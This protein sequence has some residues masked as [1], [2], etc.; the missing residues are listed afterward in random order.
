MGLIDD[1]RLDIGDDGSIA[2]SGSSSTTL[3]PNY[4]PDTFNTIGDIR[5]DIGDDSN[6]VFATGSIQVP[7]NPNLCEETALL[8]SDIRIDVGDD[9]NINYPG[10]SGI[11]SVPS[12]TICG[13]GYM[14]ISDLRLDIGDDSDVDF[15]ILNPPLPEPEAPEVWGTVYVNSN[16]YTTVQRD[17]FVLVGPSVSAPT[18]INLHTN[19]ILGQILIIKDIKGDANTNNITIDPSPNKIDGL[20]KFIMT[21]NKQSVM[22][23]WTGT[24]WNII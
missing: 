3:P 1:L 9:S 18:T 15:G 17:V 10:S 24:E 2:S 14:L 11:I 21:Q 13:Q 16:N 4:C 5:I 6:L 12:G 19:A 23:A 22:L 20:D 8:I 7:L